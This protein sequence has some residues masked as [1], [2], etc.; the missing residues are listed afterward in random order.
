ML[1]LPL[2]YNLRNLAL[3]WRTTL[4]AVMGVALVVAVYIMVESLATGLERSFVN[5]GD[6][7]NL[8]ILRKGSTADTNSQISRQQVDQLRYRP[9]VAHDA[10]GKPI[11]SAE[12][13]ILISLRRAGQKGEANVLVRGVEAPAFEL[14]PQVSLVEGRLFKGGLRE[15]IVSRRLAARFAECGL[16]QSFR[17]GKH[18]FRVVGVFDGQ[19]T[20]YD[21][22]IWMD[23]NEARSV[24]DREFFSTVLL[25]PRDEA[26]AASMKVSIEGDR[27]LSA[28]V[29][30]E[31]TYFREQTR[32]AGPIK[33]L[34]GF[35]ATVM[36]VGAVFAAMNTMYATLGRR[37][38]EIGT[39][40]VLGFRRRAILASC[41]VES[42]ALSL[43]GGGIGCLLALPLN[44]V[45]T[46]T[47]SFTT[48]SEVAFQFRITP[49]L[50]LQGMAFAL[51]IG[52]LGGFLPARAAATTPVL[53][54][55]KTA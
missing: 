6:A 12:N 15:V 51:V 31:T 13:I 21:S 34:G 46:G 17:T 5:T 47:L 41:L 11:L 8:L 10:S 54:A 32:T 23:V 50:L 42:T 37:T 35:L 22:E 16:G 7:R 18:E 25:R 52:L 4:A 20:A 3:R 1:A 39:L 30:P 24:F 29:I 55:L 26:V 14:R 28:R 44:G 53:V 36:S 48:F 9:E 40:R 2:K 27:R 33:F 49:G 43:V 45:A 38:R 19:R